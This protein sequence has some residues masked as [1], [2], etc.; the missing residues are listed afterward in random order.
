MW[1]MV[2]KLRAGWFGFEC[3]SYLC[4][5]LWKVRQG[6]NRPCR[7]TPGFDR[8][9]G[10]PYLHVKPNRPYFDWTGIRV[11]G[12]KATPV[13]KII[14]CKYQFRIASTHGYRIL[15]DHL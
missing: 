15:A 4:S 6:P 14:G 7:P 3:V 8:R 1:G 9:R 5:W 2:G 11:R 10:E 13:N 12:G